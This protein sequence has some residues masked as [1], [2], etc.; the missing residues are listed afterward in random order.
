VSF[1]R[2]YLAHCGDTLLDSGDPFRPRTLGVVGVG[3]TGG[4]LAL[5][6]G[7]VIEEMVEFLLQGGAAHGRQV[8]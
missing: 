3:N 1:V 7:E 6:F 5:S 8:I 2:D 4:E